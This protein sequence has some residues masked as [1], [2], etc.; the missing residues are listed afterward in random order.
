MNKCD[1]IIDIC[2]TQ[3]AS[4]AIAS[5]QH[6]QQQQ[7]QQ[8]PSYSIYEPN[9]QQMHPLIYYEDP[10]SHNHHILSSA[11]SQFWDQEHYV[12]MPMIPFGDTSSGTCSA[13][14]Q[15]NSHPHHNNLNSLRS[16]DDEDE[17]ALRVDGC[18]EVGANEEREG[19]DEQSEEDKKGVVDGNEIENDEEEDESDRTNND[20]D[21][22]TNSGNLDNCNPII[23]KLEPS[24][25]F[26]TQQTNRE[27]HNEIERRRRLRIKQCCDI[28]RNLVPGLSDKTDKATVLEHT[29]KYVNHLSE[30]PNF[31]CTCDFE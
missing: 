20:S 7:Q 13:A 2:D 21:N 15:M 29:V 8:Q 22:R 27:M 1:E 19:E 12:H 16:A 9:Y 30:C 28:L 18:A 11:V 23:I 3:Q 10:I 24:D 31:N 4:S 14:M 6:L 25:C 5:N 26:S 17:D